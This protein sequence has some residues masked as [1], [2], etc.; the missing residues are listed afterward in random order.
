M[1][2]AALLALFPLL[3]A[4]QPGKLAIEEQPK[5]PTAAKIVLI[6][7][8]NIYKP[9][10]HEYVAGCAVLMDLLR[11]TPGVAPVLAV[12]WPK[13]EET[14]AGA[15]AVVFYFDGG[16]KHALLK[17]GR[18]AQIQKLADAGVGI[19]HLHQTIDYPKDFGDRVR[20]WL[21]GAWEKG[22]SIRSHWVTEFKTFPE[23]PITRGVKPFKIDD[24]FLSKVRFV[25]DMKGV[26]PLLSTVSPKA[27]P[28]KGSDDVVAWAFERPSGARAF[29]FTGGHLHVSLAEEG[30]RRFIVNGILWAASV[31]IPAAGAPVALDEKEL[32][33]YLSKQTK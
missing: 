17:D 28:G 19:V 22:Y 31:E 16:D 7:G 27:K 20:E 29:V 30:Y 14:F 13:K 11:Q 15:K 2:T 9:G 4:A 10:E 6:A 23:H 25:P 8:P 32:P 3:L 1:N 18:V 26:T 21:G 5:D 12:E 33:K 24:G